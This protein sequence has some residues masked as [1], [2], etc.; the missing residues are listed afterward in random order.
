MVAFTIIREE[1]THDDI[2]SYW[3]NVPDDILYDTFYNSSDRSAIDVDALDE[4]QWD[5]EAIRLSSNF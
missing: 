4:S 1:P 3:E 5:Q 2:R